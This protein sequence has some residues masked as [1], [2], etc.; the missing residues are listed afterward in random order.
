MAKTIHQAPIIT[1]SKII[2]RAT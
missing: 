1:N 2:H